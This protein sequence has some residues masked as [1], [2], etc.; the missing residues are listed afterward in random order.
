[1]KYQD[2]ALLPAAFLSHSL[3]DMK[4]R[5]DKASGL[6]FGFKVPSKI[7]PLSF[8]VD[9]VQLS[10]VDVNDIKLVKALFAHADPVQSR[11][12]LALLLLVPN[13]VNSTGL[14]QPH[15]ATV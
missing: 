7:V 9:N 11:L 2:L 14:T 5:P 15:S 4:T 12:C 1:M 3:F 10:F 13:R 6:G 8:R